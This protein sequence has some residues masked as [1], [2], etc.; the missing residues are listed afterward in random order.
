LPEPASKP[1][2]GRDSETKPLVEGEDFYRE[3]PYV[4][5]T[6]G[7][8]SAARVLLRV[9]MP[10]LPMAGMSGVPSQRVRTPRDFYCSWPM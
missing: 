9:G 6:E 7:L 5:F 10:T 3:G 2:A 4:V 8:P 1:D